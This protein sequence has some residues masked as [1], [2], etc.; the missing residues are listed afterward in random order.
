LR[1]V[2]LGTALGADLGTVLGADLGVVLGFVLATALG[3]DL[4]ADFAFW[5]FDNFNDRFNM[6]DIKGLILLSS[7][8]IEY[9]SYNTRIFLY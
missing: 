1:L 8:I 3:A 5:H 6:A 7:F 9:I 2:V 4:G